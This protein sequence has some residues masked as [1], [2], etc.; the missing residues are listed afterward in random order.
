VKKILAPSLSVVALVAL[1]CVPNSALQNRSSAASSGGGGGGNPGNQPAAPSP[2]AIRPDPLAFPDASPGLTSTRDVTI[3]NVDAGGPVTITTVTVTSDTGGAF[4]LSV[5][6][7]PFSLDPGGSVTFQGVFAPPSRGTYAAFLEVEIAGAPARAVAINGAGVANGLSPSP[8]YVDFGTLAHGSAVA[9]TRVAVVSEGTTQVR[10]VSSV[11]VTDDGGGVYSLANV[12]PFPA[13]VPPGGHTSW[14]VLCNPSRVGAIAGELV[15]SSDDP[16]RPQIRV[17]LRVLIPDDNAPDEF[18]CNPTTSLDQRLPVVA[19]VPQATASGAVAVVLYSNDA[20][21]GTDDGEGGHEHFGSNGLDASGHWTTNNTRDIIHHTDTSAGGSSYVGYI[22]LC[23]DAFSH[24]YYAPA[25]YHPSLPQGYTGNHP[26]GVF[27]NVVGQSGEDDGHTNV[28]DGIENYG[29]TYSTLDIACDPDGGARLVVLRAGGG[30]EVPN[31][32]VGRAVTRG[33]APLGGWFVFSTGGK[34]PR[35]AF[36]GARFLVVWEEAGAVIGHFY[37]AGGGS[38]GQNFTI[39]QA[40][41]T[42][43]PRIAGDPST[44]SFGV[45]WQDGKIEGRLVG[46]DGSLGP[47]VTVSSGGGEEPAIGVNP[48]AG[49]MVV[50]TAPDADQRGVYARALDPTFGLG[51]AAFQVNEVT[52]GDQHEGAVAWVPLVGKWLFVWTGLDGDGMG[53]KGRYLAP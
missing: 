35:V 19:A 46:G 48:G 34:N 5:P 17:P 44:G 31:G 6:A 22:G 20:N 38:D 3:Q 39:A 36:N 14:Q 49:W 37:T 10:T 51:A 24:L 9:V 21:R 11:T 13:Q 15:V 41:G 42:L 28:S 43:T 32:L 8:G 45:V 16:A 1:S 53:I 26:H 40:A 7:T 23:G 52:A 29:Q 2:I 33:G 30:G 50:Y 4:T 12:P 25:R 18:R 27:M 47:V